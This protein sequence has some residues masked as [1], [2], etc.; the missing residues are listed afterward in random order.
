MATPYSDIYNPFLEKIT[1]SDLL[2]LT[3]ENRETI[4]HGLMVRTCSKFKRICK[5]AKEINLSNR[6]DTNKVFNDTLSEEIIDIITTG[7]IVEWLKPKYL[8]DQNMRNILNTKDYSMAA[9][10]AN[11][12]NSIRATYLEAKNE[13]ESMMNKFSFVNSSD[14]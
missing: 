1:D 10:P 3:I 9:S 11:M 13:F 6:D 2:A 7:M 4:L 14:N 12:A 5:Y 8:F